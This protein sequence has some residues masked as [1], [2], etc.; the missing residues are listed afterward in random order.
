[1]GLPSALQFCADINRS[2]GLVG[3]E[4]EVAAA[5]E[6]QA[7]GTDGTQK[8]GDTESW[9]V[10]SVDQGKHISTVLG[11]VLRTSH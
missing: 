10:L 1:M 3:T 8:S 9:S 7:I 6:A 4:G 11:D 2:L 5:D